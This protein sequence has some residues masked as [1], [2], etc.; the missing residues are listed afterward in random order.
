MTIGVIITTYNNPAWLE[1]TLWGYASQDRPAD[2][3][4]IADDGSGVETEELVKRYA[5]MLPIKHIW[6]EDK[7]FRKTLIL[8]KALL[9]AESDYIVMTDHDCIPRR[10]FLAVHEH[11]ARPGTFLSGGYFR[12]PMETSRAIGRDDVESQRAFN[13]GW[14]RS[15]G[16][17]Y[18]FKTTKLIRNA[19]FSR[20][21]NAATPT[22]A[23][24]NG[25][26]SST[27][28]TLLLDAGGFDERMQYGGL[29]REL[30]ERLVNAG[31]KTRQIRYSA[32]V[33]HLD[34]SRP[35]KRRD[36]W[37]RN[38]AIRKETKHLRRTRTPYG[39]DMLE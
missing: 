2:E 39:I 19:A 7:G 6:H 33:L 31:I 4:I 24:W 20:F 29:D 16:L 28:R 37:E 17:K 38:L 30:G 12:L 22:R 8:N 13:L 14:L 36:I 1:K 15:H 27:W 11:M 9:A 25:M 18:S 23:T 26:N 5:A 34:H 3:I 35:Y 21:M 10:D 32:I